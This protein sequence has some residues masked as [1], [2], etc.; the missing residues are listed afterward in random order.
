MKRLWVFVL[1]KVWKPR[2]FS[3]PYFL[4]PIPIFLRRGKFA[5]QHFGFSSQGAGAIHIA[6]GQRCLRLLKKLPDVRD[7]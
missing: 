5:Q 6:G 7:R 2:C 1:H 4:F 3:I